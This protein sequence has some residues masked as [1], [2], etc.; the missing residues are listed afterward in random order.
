M[1]KISGKFEVTMN[2]L[3]SDV[4]SE[5]N[6]FARM[7]I[8]KTYFGDLSGTSQGEM[9]SLRTAEAGSAGYV[10]IELVQATLDGKSGEFALQHNGLMSSAGQSLQLQVIPDSG[11]SD[12]KGLKGEMAIR[13]EDGVH[14]YDFEYTLSA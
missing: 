10:A 1:K 13:I 4:N 5:N 2:P 8:E 9:L 11:T 14:Y 6:V 12:L 7:G 3:D